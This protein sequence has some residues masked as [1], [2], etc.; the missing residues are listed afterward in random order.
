MSKNHREAIRIMAERDFNH[1]D[2]LS[3][4]AQRHPKVF[5]DAV[6]ESKREIK[7]GWPTATSSF[8][9]VPTSFQAPFPARSSE[10]P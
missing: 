6:A 4:I 2:V 3:I 10:N 5:V 7:V 9:Q 8:V 1:A